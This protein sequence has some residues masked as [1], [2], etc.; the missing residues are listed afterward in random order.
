MA[1]K[2]T[3]FYKVFCA[4]LNLKNVIIYQIVMLSA[5]C[6]GIVHPK[7]KVLSSFA[8][9]LVIANIFFGVNDSFKKVSYIE[10]LVILHIQNLVCISL[11]VSQHRR[12]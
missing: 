9:P 6:K 8:Y 11:V 4:N 1:D 3:R 12:V 10:F 7:M 5:P 2:Y